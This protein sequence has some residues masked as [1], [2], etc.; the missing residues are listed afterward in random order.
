MHK[1]VRN[2]FAAL[3]IIFMV[4]LAIPAVFHSA[5]TAHARAS[6]NKTTAEVLQ[7]ATIK[8]RVKGAGGQV[9]WKSKRPSVATVDQNGVVTGNNPGTAYIIAKASGKRFKCKVRV[10][11]LSNVK[12]DGAQLGIDVS[13]WQGKINFKK[14]KADGISYVIMRAGIGQKVDSTFYRNYKQAKK[15]GLKVG[16]YWFITATSESAA[17]AQARKCLKTISGKHFELPVFV[18]IESNSQF[19]KGKTF[20]SDIISIFCDAVKAGGYTP[21]WYTSRS[22]ISSY[23]TDKVE[24]G[25]G[26]VKW[27]AE[28]GKTLHYNSVCH[29]WQFSHTGRVN[30]INGYVDLNWYFPSAFGTQQTQTAQTAQTEQKSTETAS[31][32]QA[33]EASTEQATEAS[34]EKATEA[35]T[36]TSTESSSSTSSAESTS[37]TE[38]SSSSSGS[39]ASTGETASTSSGTA[40]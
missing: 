37:S 4:M 29:I 25:S 26:Y 6:I 3:L 34:T 16:C 2:L 11:T 33:A 18:D 12:T 39:S 35:A 13:V 28:H 7:G 15:Y 27:V 24:N 23:L 14:V 9:T 5:H 19:R 40:A 31:T 17:A 32:E 21:G 36:E 1:T 30:G 8:L 10:R 38:T 22:F 20:C